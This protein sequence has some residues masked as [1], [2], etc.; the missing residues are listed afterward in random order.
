MER[1]ELKNENKKEK[2]SERQRRKNK[3]A[4]EGLRPRYLCSWHTYYEE[5]F[6]SITS[7]NTMHRF[8]TFYTLYNRT[9]QFGS[10]EWI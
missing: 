6:I 3:C 2:R 1:K 8:F 5:A 10:S 9:V 7:S 4:K